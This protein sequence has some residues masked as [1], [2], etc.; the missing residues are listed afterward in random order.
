MVLRIW[1]KLQTTVTGGAIL[2]SGSWFISK[3]LGL[4]RERMIAARYAASPESDAYYAAFGLPDFI[5]GTLILGSLFSVFIPVF[6]RYRQQQ[7]EEAFRVAN[8][9]LNLIVLVFSLFAVGLFLFAPQAVRLIAP[10]FDQYRLDMTV[11]LT[12]IIAVNIILFGISNVL[13]GIL[14]ASRRFVEFSIAPIL[15]N[16]GILFG[17]AVLVP[18]MG[19]RGVAVGALIGAVLHLAVQLPAVT[20]AGFRYRRILDFRHPGVREIGRLLLPRAFGQSVTQIA[21]LINVVI[22]STLVVGSVSIFR[23][24]TNV[25]DLPVTLIGVS[26]ATVVFPVFSEA[27]NNDDRP[28]FVEHF[29]RV[30]RQILFL[31][32]PI[33]ILFLQL[34]A[35]ATRVVYGSGQFDWD[36]TILTANTVGFFALSFFAQSLI[37]V[38]ARSFYAMRDTATPVKITM[39]AVA[40]NIAGSFLFSRGFDLGPIH[41]DGLGVRGL[42]LSYS[43]ANIVGMVLMYVVLRL[44]I[45]DLDDDRVVRTTLRIILAT[46]LMAFLVQG[47]KETVVRLGI[48]LETGFGVLTQLL[49]SGSLGIIAYLGFAAALNMDEVRSVRQWIGRVR[50]QLFNGRTE[51]GNTN[52]D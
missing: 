26:I 18:S 21:Q 30:V 7:S 8:S 11:D 39:L 40:L 51:N 13:S 49:V 48:T 24:A 27:L 41:F 19:I 46:T 5:Y 15:Y 44:R 42:A 23:Y 47:V 16:L 2:V 34:R 25:Q 28:R 14:N 32:I 9:I 52:G 1:R 45:G 22:G 33:S 36:A 38:L 50:Q 4:L 17:L 20:A 29:S 10:G 35:Q 43:I 3:L 37:P 12:R 6:I 31:V